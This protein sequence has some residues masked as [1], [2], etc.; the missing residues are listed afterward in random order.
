MCP[1]RTTQAGYLRQPEHAEPA[2][3]LPLRGR[4]QVCK[5]SLIRLLGSVHVDPSY[6][7]KTKQT[8]PAASF[9]L[10]SPCAVLMRCRT[11]T[12]LRR[13]LCKAGPAA[14]S[15]RTSLRAPE[16]QADGEP[17]AS[18]L[19]TVR[20]PT[21]H[22]V[23]P[24]VQT[25]QPDDTASP[26]KS[27]SRSYPSRR[28]VLLDPRRSCPRSQPGDHPRGYSVYIRPRSAQ[29]VMAQVGRQQERPPRPNEAADAPLARHP[30]YPSTINARTRLLEV[31]LTQ[32]Q[33]RRRLDEVPRWPAVVD[34]SPIEMTSISGA[35]LPRTSSPASYSHRRP[36]ELSRGWRL[37]RRHRSPHGDPRR[38]PVSSAV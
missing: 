8:H 24:T 37:V 23:K 14:C 21:Q 32:R 11:W 1:C 28:P 26:A 36:P 7:R 10:S 20:S 15:R 18:G 31:P 35:L 19:T 17:M 6:E 9:N 34:S 16:G 2:P 38:T 3:A 5:S 25:V 12:E 4:T 33:S 27:Q 13:R 29:L 22:H 30:H